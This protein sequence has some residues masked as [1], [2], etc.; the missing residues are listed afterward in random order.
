MITQL[1]GDSL[2]KPDGSTVSTKEA[3]GAKEVV[4]LYFSAHWCPPCRGFT[5]VLS[6]KYTKLVESGKSFEL[7]F[8]SSD[9]DEAAFNDYH[10]E[11]TFL[12]LPYAERDLKAK[13]SKKFK[14]QGIPTLVFL[15]GQTGELITDDGRSE[16]SS[17]KFIENFPYRPQPL[18]ALLPEA[19]GTTLNKPD[20]T[21]VATADVLKKPVLGLY[22]SAHWCPPCR[23][24]TPVLSEKY[25]KLKEAGKDFDLVFVSS[26][27]DQAAFD[28]YHKEM[29]FLALPF[30]ERDAKSKLSSA[31]KVQGIPSLVFVDTVTWTVITSEGRGGISSKSF[32]E[33][34]P[35]HPK[36]VNDLAGTVDGINDSVSLVVLME[37]AS[38]EKQAE[39]TTLVNTIAETEF[40]KK[41]DERTVERFFTACGGGPADRVRSGCG[42]A[43]ADKATPV[44]LLLDLDDEG[45]YY[46]PEKPEVTADNIKTFV[47]AFKS[48]KL[49]RKQFS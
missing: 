7:V 9:R 18:S 15:D 21:T 25:T 19:L 27:R 11:M 2:R 36:P 35:Y 48:K 4:G 22:F 8:V 40:A 31:F 28:E 39:I 47:E 32:I 34:F 17:D 3:T 5:P 43:D 29:S 41:E 30:K 37:G 33:D 20:G 14:V 42:Y 10:K 1:L 26:D 49:T 6:E 46:H 24:F 38:E 45:A 23:G 16:I 12:A 44:M 13:L